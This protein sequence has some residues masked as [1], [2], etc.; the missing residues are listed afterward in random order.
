MAVLSHKEAENL[1][2]LLLRTEPTHEARQSQTHF[3]LHRSLQVVVLTVGPTIAALTRY[4]DNHRRE[5]K[6]S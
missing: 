2:E 6:L 1:Q 3:A 5:A 4:P